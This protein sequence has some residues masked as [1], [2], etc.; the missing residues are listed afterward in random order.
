MGKPDT[1]KVHPAIAK[2]ALELANGNK[3][4][5]YSRYI[6][7]YFRQTGKLAPGCDNKDLQAFYDKEGLE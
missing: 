5:A 6:Q 1:N 3:Q 2:R 4:A 7:L